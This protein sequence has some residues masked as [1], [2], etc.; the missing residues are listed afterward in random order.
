MLGQAGRNELAKMEATT[1]RKKK[2]TNQ[3]EMTHL[4]K[5]DYFKS[6]ILQR[7]E[8]LPRGLLEFGYYLCVVVVTICFFWI[9][10]NKGE[11]LCQK[12]ILSGDEKVLRFKKRLFD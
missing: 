11:S 12:V 4:A 8:S 1:R 9:K 6:K 3:L 10:W 2:P 7:V 5:R